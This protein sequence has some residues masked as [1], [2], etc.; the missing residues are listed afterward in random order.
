MNI[1][2]RITKKQDDLFLYEEG[3]LEKSGELSDEGR[4]VVLNLIFLGYEIK[5]VR[6]MIVREIKKKKKEDK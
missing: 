4:K 3:I 1:F 6:E 2:T 5:E